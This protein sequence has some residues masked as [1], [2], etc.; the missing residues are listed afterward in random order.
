MARDAA[1]SDSPARRVTG[2]SAKKGERNSGGGGTLDI[3]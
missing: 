2:G 3:H 1:Q